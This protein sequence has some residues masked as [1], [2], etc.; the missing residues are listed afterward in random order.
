MLWVYKY[1]ASVFI[2]VIVRIKLS[3]HMIASF[4][5]SSSAIIH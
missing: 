1:S 4:V 2:R 5:D 3:S